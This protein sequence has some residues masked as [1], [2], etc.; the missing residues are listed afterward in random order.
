METES[1]ESAI[2]FSLSLFPLYI[3]KKKA[4]YYLSMAFFFSLLSSLTKTMAIFVFFV[5]I[6]REDL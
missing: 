3:S 1:L 4:E 2:S 6:N 5:F